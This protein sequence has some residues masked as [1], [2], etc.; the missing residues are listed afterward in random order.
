MTRT[1]QLTT[2]LLDGTLTEAE[3]AELEALVASDPRAEAEHLALLELEAEL[4]GLR[5]DFD[6]ADATLAKVQ[7][8]Q[9]ERTTQAV[10]TEIASAPPPMWARPAPAPAPLPEPRRRR[11]VWA[12]GLIAFAAALLFALWLGGRNPVGP[13]P[14]S[15]PAP[16]AFAKLSRKAGAVEVVNQAGD[17]I[18]AE[19]GGE[20]PAGFTL[21]TVGEDSLAVVELLRDQTRVEIESDSVVRFAGDAPE[22]GKPRLFLAAGQLT[23]AV[24]QRPDDRPL[25]VGTAVAEVFARG[26][27]F[28]V[29]SAGPDSARV[30]NKQGKVELVRAVAPKPVSVV[31]GGAAVILAGAD[32]LDIERAPLVDRT[33]KRT[34]AYQGYRDAVFSADGSEVWV[35]SARVFGR[36]SATGGFQETGFFPRR[37]DGVAAFTRDRRF[38]VTFRGERDDRV[39][40]RT[41]PDAG[42]HAAINARPADPRLWAVAPDAE[43]LAVIDPRPNNK[44]VRVFDGRAGDEQFV[45]E[46]DDPLTCLAAAPNGN[47]FAVAVTATG[48]GASN[49]VVVL[50]AITSDRLYAL[51]VLKRPVT[52]MTFSADGRLLAVGFNGTVQVWD[53]RTLELARSITGFER[54]L[55]CVAFSP[56]GKRLAA[57]TQ[58][59]SVWV[60]DTDTGKQTQLI[61][62][63]SRGLR[64]VA[65]SPN[66]KQLVTVANGAPVA[67]WDVSDR[68]LAADIQ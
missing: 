10:M 65:F 60:W 35:A 33:P 25:V 40:V 28:V 51:S 29:S 8:A 45:R 41:L 23:A 46:F 62:V 4:R 66:G 63:G 49:K 31:A 32:R 2:K 6:L 56:D 64:T 37:G 5:T 7:E 42:E 67:V 34:L 47:H 21:R 50:D 43:W 44:R 27:T 39:L 19:E 20:L 18:P 55:T 59:G 36:W 17:A 12:G 11:A 9:A 52:A 30:D 3:W 22:T 53:T 48:R 58:D 38:L 54:V 26:G 61:E 24:P 15:E 14:D 57:G 16:T 13:T 68:P 1:A